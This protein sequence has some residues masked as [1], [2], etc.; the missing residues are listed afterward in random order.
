MRTNHND[1]RPRTRGRFNRLTRV[2]KLLAA[3]AS[4]VITSGAV[5]SAIT[6]AL[7][8]SERLSG[9]DLEGARVS[10]GIE[11]RDFVPQVITTA[12]KGSATPKPRIKVPRYGARVTALDRNSPA[13]RAGLKVGDLIT[14]V[15][16][17]K[18]QD[19]DA[20]S[21]PGNPVR[22]GSLLLWYGVDGPGWSN[23]RRRWRASHDRGTNRPGDDSRVGSK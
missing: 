13:S 5:A 7:D 23:S 22:C 15:N 19:V 2:Q 4:P 6:A 3:L 10:L 18:V 12:K 17:R 16:G 21:H 20:E 14:A 8:L 9:D 11:A 1:L